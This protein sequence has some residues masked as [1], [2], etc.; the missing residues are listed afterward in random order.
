[1]HEN[2]SRTGPAN[3]GSS[4]RVFGLFFSLLF[5]AT[6]MMPLTAGG[7]VRLWALAPCALLL[8]ASLLAP[9]ILSPLNRFWTRI[10]LLLNKVT[11]PIVLGV[12]FFLVITPISLLLRSLNKKTLDVGPDPEAESY[13]FACSRNDGDSMKNQ[14]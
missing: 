1:M 10:G 5:F 9:S 13:W 8:L 4:D 6:A 3:S 2:H 12:I 7:R 14:F 11:N